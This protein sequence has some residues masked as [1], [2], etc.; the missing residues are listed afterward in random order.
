MHTCMFVYAY[1]YTRIGLTQITRIFW[2]GY[3]LAALYIFSESVIIV[4][5]E[6]I[7][8]NKKISGFPNITR[9]FSKYRGLL[10]KFISGW[11]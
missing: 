7:F 8:I 9:Y 4:D 1:A 3:I 6:G 5:Y 2:F 10:I 11:N